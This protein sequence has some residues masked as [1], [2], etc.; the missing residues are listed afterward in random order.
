MR[1]DVP[2]DITRA[3]LAADP[4]IAYLL[5][6]PEEVQLITNRK[7]R[8]KIQATLDWYRDGAPVEFAVAVRRQDDAGIPGEV[9]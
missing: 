6:H 4:D 1:W 7:M 9:E 5:E 3:E 2:A 8:R